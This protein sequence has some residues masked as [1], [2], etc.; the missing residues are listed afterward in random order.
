MLH[1]KTLRRRGTVQKVFKWREK[2]VRAVMAEVAKN[3]KCELVYLT[4]DEGYGGYNY[5]CSGGKV[6]SL[7]P[8]IKVESGVRLDGQDYPH[9]CENP[10]ECQF[11]TFFHEL[12]HVKLANKV[13]SNVKGYCW[14]DTSNFQYE[15]W[16]TM[17][18][19]EYAHKKYGIKFS[20]YAVTWL[21][22]EAKTYIRENEEETGY[23]LRLLNANEQG[24]DLK[25]EWEFTGENEKRTSKK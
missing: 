11:I 4:K 17:L 10:L 3:E 7:A 19:V 24:Y 21:L 13:P 16:I 9:A 2:D 18:G 25:S 22:E 1:T 8:F 20:D 23:G 5:G 14:N 15:M 12:A 6:I